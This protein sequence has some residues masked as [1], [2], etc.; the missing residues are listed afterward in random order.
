MTVTADVQRR[1]GVS[2]TIPEKGWKRG[3]THQP[4]LLLGA[5]RPLTATF[6]PRKFPLKQKGITSLEINSLNSFHPS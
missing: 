4:Q 3:T 2:L 5:T 1:A 6:P